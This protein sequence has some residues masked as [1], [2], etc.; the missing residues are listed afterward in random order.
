MSTTATIESKGCQGTGITEELAKSLHDNLGKTIVAV[1][2]IT[3][4]KRSEN[5]K[6]DEK[7][8]LVINTI[9]VAPN[10]DTA[11]HIRELSHAFNYERKLVENGPTLPGTDDEP[12][13]KVADILAAGDAI[14]PH[15]FV[16]FEEDGETVCDRCGAG[17]GDIPTCTT[18]VTAS[19]FW[20]PR[21]ETIWRTLSTSRPPTNPPR[22][23]RRPRPPHRHRRNRT[24]AAPPTSSTSSSSLHR[25]RLRTPT[26]PT[27]STPS[28]AAAAPSRPSPAASNAPPPPARQPTSTTSSNHRTPHRS[29]RQPRQP[30]TPTTWSPVDLA[31]SS[32]ANTSTHHP[33]CSCA[34][35]ASL[36]YDGAVHTISGESESGKTWLTLIAALQLSDGR[37]RRLRRLRRPR[38][39]RHRPPPRPRRHPPQIRDHFAYIRPD[40]PLD[41]DGRT[42]LAPAL[43]DARLVIIDGVTEAMTMH[44]YD[45]NSNADSATF[46]GLLPRWIADHGPAVVMIDHVV[47]DKEKQDRFALG[48]QHKL[49]GIDG[50]AYIV[51]MI[52]PFARGNRGLA[53][54]DIAKDR[55]GHVREH[56]HG[57]TIAEFTLDATRSDVVLIAHLM[58]P[59]AET[60]RAGDTFEPTVLMEKIS[61]YVQLNPGMSKKAIEDAVNGKTTTKRLALELLVTRGYVGTKTGPAA[62]SSTSTSS[63]TTRPTSSP[64]RG[65]NLPLLRMH[66]RQRLLAHLLVDRTR[67]LLLLRRPP[68]TTDE[69]MPCG[70][71]GKPH[72]RCSA[73]RRD[74]EPCTQRPMHGQRVCKMHGGLTPGAVEKAEERLAEAGAQKAIASLWPGLAGAERVKDPVAALGRLAGALEQM[75][76]VVGARVNELHG[77][78]GGE[79]MTQLRG[80]VVLLD[81]LLAHSRAVL[82]DM[83][84]LNLGQRQVEIEEWQGQMLGHALVAALAEIS[85]LE[86]PMRDRVIRGVLGKLGWAPE[87]LELDGPDGVP[88]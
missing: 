32:P 49:A 35:T 30:P 25:P 24:S 5:R 44:G 83:A 22:P 9:E 66:R 40:R 57:R 61:R 15:E 26:T 38:R 54:V 64:G 52:Q 68:M 81:K 79:S 37:Q 58:P 67:P 78:A 2:E 51:K 84:R 65:Q 62:P 11:E 31:P 4:D 18:L 7:V 48:A 87:V 50:V 75:T 16:P 71:C 43:T 13:P 88:A 12:A 77:I 3:A 60:G 70:R 8:G 72:A 21:H 86:V 34:P 56:A 36:F 20:Q 82:T 69:P 29:P 23:H 76:E 27:A 42:Q 1:V 80:E 63:P 14:K 74:G 47:K 59:G 33:P 6:G 55:P 28:P 53:R 45:L 41:D 85:E 46:Q 17:E 39:P 19:D 10:P 73:H